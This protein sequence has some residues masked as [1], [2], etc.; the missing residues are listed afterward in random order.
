M[1]CSGWSYEDWRGVVY[2]EGLARRRWLSCYA[3]RFAT[4]EVNATF[5]RLPRR[6]TVE[7]WAEQ[8]PE[9]FSFAVKASR[10]LTHIKRLG[11]VGEG[12]ATFFERIEPLREADRMGPVLWQLPESFH[13]D[14]RALERTLAALPAGR[15]A[16]ELRHAS[17]FRSSVYRLLADHGA[18]LVIGD[19]P[20]R[21]FQTHERTAEWTYVR[22]HHG[23]RGARGNYSAAELERWKR[24]IAAW[25]AETEVYVYLNNDWEGFAPRNAAVLRQGLSAAGT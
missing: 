15:H 10:Y 8:T 16:F 3:Q 6:S 13:R 2:P 11:E 19:H 17:W 22:L 21:P 4:V 14:E 18:A 12:I 20:E 25:R 7:S 9:G 5:Y 24:R 23:R 1:G